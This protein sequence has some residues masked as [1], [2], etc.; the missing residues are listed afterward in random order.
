MKGEW[1]C[2]HDFFISRKCERQYEGG[3]GHEYQCQLDTIMKRE[4]SKKVY[5][6][7]L[8]SGSDLLGSHPVFD[9]RG[10]SPFR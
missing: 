8:N 4:K 3:E 2:C 5:W 7:E 1:D 10:G 6:K 9:T